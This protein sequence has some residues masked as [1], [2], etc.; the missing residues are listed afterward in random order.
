MNTYIEIID[1]FIGGVTASTKFLASSISTGSVKF[2]PYEDIL[3]VGHT[4]GL[5]TI[6]V[7]GN[8]YIYRYI[9][10]R[11]DHS[12]YRYKTQST[13]IYICLCIHTRTYIRIYIYIHIHKYCDVRYTCMHMNINR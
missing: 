11:S 8:T 3:A 4:H 2:R 9:Y 10:I 12:I 1:I 13:G 6:I 5:S 7:P